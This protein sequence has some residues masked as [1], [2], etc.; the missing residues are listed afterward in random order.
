MFCNLVAGD[1][2]KLFNKMRMTK[3]KYNITG[4]MCDMKILAFDIAI[5]SLIVCAIALAVGGLIYIR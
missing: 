2:I 5:F 1:N 3:D 4:E